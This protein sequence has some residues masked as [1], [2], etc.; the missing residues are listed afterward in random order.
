MNIIITQGEYYNTARQ[1]STWRYH[2]MMKKWLTSVAIAVLA[3]GLITACAPAEEEPMPE[4]PIMED[5]NGIDDPA[6]TPDEEPP[7]DE[8]LETDPDADMDDA[9]EQID[10]DLEDDETGDELAED[11]DD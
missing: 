1:F 5:G 7:M 2:N 6:Q 10:V 3:V 9:E 8:P 11:E 4:D